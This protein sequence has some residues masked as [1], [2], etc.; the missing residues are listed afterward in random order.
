MENN[1]IVY[2]F[3]INYRHKGRLYLRGEKFCADPLTK[4]KAIDLRVLLGGKILRAVKSD[5]KPLSRIEEGKD[6][7]KIKD[8]IQ[9]KIKVVKTK[10]TK[11]TTKKK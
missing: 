11:K 1:N 5:G 4:D 10:V 2:I 8:T 3:N 9:E 7:I 6:S